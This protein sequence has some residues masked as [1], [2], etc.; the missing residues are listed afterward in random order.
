MVTGDGPERWDVEGV[1]K[2]VS[3]IARSGGRVDASLLRGIDFRAGS[4]RVL[5]SDCLFPR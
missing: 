3:W 4:L 5:V 2:D 1:T